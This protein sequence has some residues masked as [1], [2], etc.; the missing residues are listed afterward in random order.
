MKR[1]YAASKYTKP[2]EA[3]CR[4]HYPDE[5]EAI[6]R[7]AEDYYRDFMRDM[8][9]LGE[10]MM[11][12][13]CWTG[14]RSSLFTRRATGGWTERRCWRSSASLWS[15]CAFWEGSWTATKAGG[16]TG[17]LKRPTCAFVKCRRSIRPE[18]SGWTAGG[19]RSTPT[20]ARRASAFILSAAPSQST[21]ESTATRLRGA[22]AVSV[23]DGPFPCGDP[24]RAPY[25]DADRGARRHVLRLLVCGRSEP[26]AAGLCGAAADLNGK[27][28][29][30]R[31]RACL[32]RALLPL[33]RAKERKSL[34]LPQQ[35]GS[36]TKE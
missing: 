4:K 29:R 8:P 31:D 10:N 33:L 20:T 21:P 1:A 16:C 27:K 30:A 23:Q 2:C 12:K 6:L 24:A 13:I 22:A 32:F 36:M 14:S 9:D 5:A 11:A 28:E 19:W 7:R 15:G 26:G 18:A 34:H 3:Y 25:P 17:C 35:S